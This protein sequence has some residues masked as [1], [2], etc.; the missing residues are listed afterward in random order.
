MQNITFYVSRVVIVCGSG[1][2]Y[3]FLHTTNLSPCPNLSKESLSL[4]FEVA[5]GD[6]FRYVTEHLGIDPSLVEVIGR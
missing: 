3:V 5:A 4:D 6:G 1:P 2:D